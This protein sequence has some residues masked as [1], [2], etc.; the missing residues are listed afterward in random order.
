MPKDHLTPMLGVEE[1]Q[2]LFAEWREEFNDWAEEQKEKSNRITDELVVT[3]GIEI[4]ER[5]A[6]KA[7][8][9]IHRGLTDEET[10]GL[11]QFGELNAKL[12]LGFGPHTPPAGQ[13]L[14]ASVRAFQRGEISSEAMYAA[15]AAYGLEVDQ[16]QGLLLG[17]DMES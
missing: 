12:A 17:I 1:Y 10:A 4:A 15:M 9:L 11:L 7:I 5:I 16:L 13:E 6:G 2:P 14:M 3:A 8:D